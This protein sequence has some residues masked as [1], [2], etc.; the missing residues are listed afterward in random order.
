M[1]YAQQ[2]QQLLSLFLHC[3][4]LQSFINNFERKGVKFDLPA[5]RSWGSKFGQK[6]PNFK[7]FVRT[8]KGVSGN[9]GINYQGS[10][11]SIL[12]D[13]PRYW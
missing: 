1:S 4:M 3:N 12:V 8:K 6:D 9:F 5:G 10:F 11:E 7:K 2:Q 13:I